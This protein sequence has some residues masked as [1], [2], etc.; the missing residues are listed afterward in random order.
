MEEVKNITLNDGSTYTGSVI[1]VGENPIPH[2]MGVQKFH[3]HNESGMFNN[4]KL[5]GVCYLNYHDWMYIGICKNDETN[6]WGIKA[7]KG[8]VSF[9]VYV[10]GELKVDL[11]QLI[12]LFWHKINEIANDLDKGLAYTRKN[13][14]IF[15]G[16]PESIYSKR[17]G[18]HFLNNGEV[19]LGVCDYGRTDITGEFIHFDLDYNIHKGRYE[20]GQ[21]VEVVDDVKFISECNIFIDHAYLDFDISM[22]YSPKSFLLEKKKLMHIFEMGKTDSNLI[23]KA[24]ICSVRG[25]QIHFKRTNCSDTTWFY[26]P[27]DYEIEEELKEIMNNEEENPWAPDFSDYR[28]K[29]VNNLRASGTNHLIVYEHIS[30]WDEEGLNYDIDYYDYIDPEEYGI[31]VSNN[32]YDFDRANRRESDIMRQLIPNHMCKASE[33]SEQWRSKG[34]YYT[35]PSL[36]DYVYSLA[37]DND[38]TNFFGWLFDDHRFNGYQIWNVPINYLQ[39]FREFLKLFPSLD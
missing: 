1:Y 17:L 22:N 5:D 27:L 29:F 20:D 14:E 16:V 36:R 15:L 28:V 30:C 12:K 7:E 38:S 6:G 21:F 11:T 39:A 2:G 25:D 9:G 10:N 23:V 33:L 34:W 35:Y 13:G 8:K 18:F 4:G 32:N 19:F 26:F 3:D 31:V 24:N 37:E